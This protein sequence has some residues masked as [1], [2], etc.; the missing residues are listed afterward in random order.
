MKKLLLIVGIG[1]LALASSCGKSEPDTLDRAE[2]FT[3]SINIGLGQYLGAL[4]NSEIAAHP[5][6]NKDEALEGIFYV[7]ETDTADKS[8]FFGIDMGI[9]LRGYF[10]DNARTQPLS[11]SAFLES[12]EKEFMGDSTLLAPPSTSSDSAARALGEHYGQIGRVELLYSLPQSVNAD[13]ILAQIRMM[14]LTDTTKR[15]FIS[16]ATTGVI[17]YNYYYDQANRIGGASRSQFVS[18]L[19]RSLALDSVSSDLLA[20]LKATLDPMTERSFMLKQQRMEEEVYN[21]RA[22][23][24]NRLLGDAVAAKLISNP[25]FTAAGDKGLMM[26]RVVAGD[27]KVLLSEDEVR[28][29]LTARRIDSGAEVFSRIDV[30]MLV[31]NTYDPM[32]NNILPLMQMGETAEF[33]VPHDLAYGTLGL[34]RRGVGPCESLMVTISVKP[35]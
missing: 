20:E 27:G 28:I 18:A 21:S 8:R 5:E 9:N 12:F 10:Y 23:R 31:G 33:F 1:T 35:L 6:L 3:D 25:E 14:C 24:E 7:M 15:A 4:A 2:T 26:R 16:G 19:K 17:I 34:E 30:R 11:M 32:L 29:D 22:A 13:E